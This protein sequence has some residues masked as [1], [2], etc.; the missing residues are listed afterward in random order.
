MDEVQLA[1]AY[2]ILS[3]LETCM[4][5]RWKNDHLMTTDQVIRGVLRVS[6]ITQKN[7]LI[8]VNQILQ[9]VPPLCDANTIVDKGY[10]CC[11]SI[12]YPWWG[13]NQT[14]IVNHAGEFNINLFIRI[15]SLI[16]WKGEGQFLCLFLS[17]MIMEL[18]VGDQSFL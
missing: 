18:I 5:G 14:H 1:R 6:L 17:D 16:G 4:N 2:C 13:L 10:T 9:H 11:L 12:V 7:P 8:L 3:V 15:W